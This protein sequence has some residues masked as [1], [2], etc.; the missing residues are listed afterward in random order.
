MALVN[1]DL[2]ETRDGFA[3]PPDSRFLPGEAVHVYGQV[4]GYKVSRDYRISLSYQMRATDPDGRPFYEAE[5][6]KIDVELAPQD[7]S[8]MPVLRYSPRIPGHAGGGTYAIQILVRDELAGAS[9]TAQLP[10][11]V[12]GSRVQSA[13][14]L[15]VRN[16]SFSRTESGRPVRNP[17]F[18]AGEEIRAEFLITGYKIREDNT[19]QVESDVWVQD[20]AGQ[21]LYDFEPAGEAGNPFYPKLWLPAELRLKLDESTPPGRYAVVLRLRDRVGG[22]EAVERYHFSIRR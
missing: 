15:L 14:Q 13:D 17:V 3:I 1:L 11:T 10:I 22:T 18:G 21:R 20:A 19:Y 7:E 12:D 16:F 2:L 4:A 8:W 5:E 6:G 9:V